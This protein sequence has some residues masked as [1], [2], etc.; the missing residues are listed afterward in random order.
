MRYVVKELTFRDGSKKYSVCEK[1]FLRP[2]IFLS[3]F[4]TAQDAE[5]F[6]KDQASWPKEKI[7][8]HYDAEGKETY[9]GF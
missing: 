2:E 4:F 6:I 1:R 5:F 9:D 7:V 3:V 8:A